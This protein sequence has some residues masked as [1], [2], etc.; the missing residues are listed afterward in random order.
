M[1]LKFFVGVFG[2]LHLRR[3]WHDYLLFDI[4]YKLMNDDTTLQIGTEG[5]AP[6]KGIRPHAREAHVSRVQNSGAVHRLA[7]GGPVEALVVESKLGSAPL[8]PSEF[9]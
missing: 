4:H 1:R 2:I 6:G 5:I 9:C 7:R 8:A 3:I